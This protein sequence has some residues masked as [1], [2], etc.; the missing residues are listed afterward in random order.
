MRTSS[1]VRSPCELLRKINDMF[2]G[3]SERDLKVRRLC[4]EAESATKRLAQELNKHKKEAWKGWWALNK[5]FPYEVKM[6]IDDNYKQEGSNQ[7]WK[8]HL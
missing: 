6:R 5:E 2:Q 3:D 8:K 1:P 7:E 4:A